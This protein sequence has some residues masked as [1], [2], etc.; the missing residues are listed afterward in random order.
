M[1][2]KFSWPTESSNVL[3]V[4][5][6]RV[7]PSLHNRYVLR[8]RDRISKESRSLKV[9]AGNQLEISNDALPGPA[10]QTVAWVDEIYPDGESKPLT[11]RVRVDALKHV[12]QLERWLRQP[13]QA[14][15]H[16]EAAKMLETL[17]TWEYFGD[18]EWQSR[19]VRIVNDV[20][21]RLQRIHRIPSNSRLAL[22]CELYPVQAAH[23]DSVPGNVMVSLTVMKELHAV[24]ERHGASTQR[25]I[26]HVTSP[27]DGP[28]SDSLR[29]DLRDL[30]ETSLAFNH[31]GTS[32]RILRGQVLSVLEGRTAALREFRA[33]LSSGQQLVKSFYLDMGSFTYG[34]PETI[35]GAKNVPISW[36]GAEIPEATTGTILYSANIEFLRR[37]MAR[38]LFYACAEPELH[39]HF[40]LVASDAE[41]RAFI[42]E[43]EDLSRTIHG[44][45]HRTSM[46]PSLS[47]SSSQLPPEVGNPI[48]YFACARYL[49][50]GQ[51]M[52]KFGTDVWVQDVD[53]YP[54]S[55]ISQ[56]GTALSGFDVVLAAS[57]GINM[58]APWRRYIAN[59][60]YISRSEKGR[61][62]ATNAAQYISAFLDEPDSWMLDQ[63]AL[64]WAVEKAP[65]GTS[66][67]NMRALDIQLTQ[68]A[69]NGS[70]E[71]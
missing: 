52:D 17:T 55:P 62:F 12:A 28:V 23:S 25:E 50:A 35:A 1:P 57:S 69:M 67:G 42:R 13:A 47:W 8:L 33:A 56:A 4:D 70:I 26:F 71:S 45:S 40:H 31:P 16:A 36:H 64:D 48:T 58:L 46:P 34:L 51:V 32:S 54:T 65:A 9:I 59:S 7:A 6:T 20:L 41:A 19:L 24:L 14:A 10:N 11:P 18:S 29:A 30:L 38:I 27:S 22:L 61:A 39:L 2:K 5:L 43:A 66:I 63:N 60:V 44:F 21:R 49:V 37:Y 3:T 53:L 15:T 68:S